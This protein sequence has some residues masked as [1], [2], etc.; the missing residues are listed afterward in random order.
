M[1]VSR[2]HLT[3]GAMMDTL[4]VTQQMVQLSPWAAFALE[5]A[6]HPKTPKPQ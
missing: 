1:P 2:S 5:V 4:Q 3:K 6:K